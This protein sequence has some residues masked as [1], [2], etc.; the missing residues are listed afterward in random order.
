MERGQEFFN[1]FNHDFAR[2]A[3]GVPRV[4]VADPA[5]NAQQTVELMEQA[6]AEHAVVALFPE[7]GLSAYSCDDLFHQRALLDGVRDGLLR[8]VE[9]SERLPLLT[10]VGLPLQVEHVLFNCAAVIHRG[11]VLGI[12]PKTYLPNYREFYEARYFASG[13]VARQTS[14]E[15]AGQIVPFGSRLLFHAAQQPKFTFHVEICEDVWVP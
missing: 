14:V 1:L 4:R 7:L 5:Y 15:L 2:L 3:V 6:V 12:V 13:D 8:I 10:V 11:R 9:A